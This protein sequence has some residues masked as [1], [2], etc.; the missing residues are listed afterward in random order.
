M[1]SLENLNVN[2]RMCSVRISEDLE[3]KLQEAA[4][5]NGV[6]VSDFIRQH[7]QSAV[8]APTREDLPTETESG[9]MDPRVKLHLKLNEL[10]RLHAHKSAVDRQ[11]EEGGGKPG[12]IFSGAPK[13]LLEAQA[14]VEGGLRQLELEIRE[15]RRDIDVLTESQ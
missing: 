6:N 1:P 5:Q 9:G 15:I 12:L 13:Y 4:A 8:D 10:Q 14:A 2:N 3:A 11:V 7:L